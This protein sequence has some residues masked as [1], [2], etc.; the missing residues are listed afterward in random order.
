[1]TTNELLLIIIGILF[2]ISGNTYDLIKSYSIGFAF[3]VLGIFI[4]I[5]SSFITFLK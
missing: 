1:M 3:K 5:L 2:T 4:L